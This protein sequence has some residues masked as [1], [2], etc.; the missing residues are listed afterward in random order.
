MSHLSRA[1]VAAG[2]TLCVLAAVFLGVRAV[3]GARK[4]LPGAAVIGWAL[5]YLG[6]GFPPPPPPQQHAE[7]TDRERAA[8]ERGGS[9]TGPKPER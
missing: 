7:D 8:R 2:I 1:A 5:L 4:G 6:F 3:S 9:D